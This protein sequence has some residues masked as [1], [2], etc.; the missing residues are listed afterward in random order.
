M[1][2]DGLALK[3]AIMSL[4]LACHQPTEESYGPKDEVVA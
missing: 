2:T 1:L 4:V 3:I